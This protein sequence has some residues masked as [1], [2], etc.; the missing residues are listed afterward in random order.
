MKV[1][2][3]IFIIIGVI[4]IIMGTAMFG[5]IGIAVW[6]GA[7]TLYKENVKYNYKDC[8]SFYTY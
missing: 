8:F 6:I 3:I 2:G 7:S 4:G 5:D 1:F